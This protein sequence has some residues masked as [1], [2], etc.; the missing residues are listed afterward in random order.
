[1][2]ALVG[3]SLLML[4]NKII[5]LCVALLSACALL[6][7]YEP[8]SF[9]VSGDAAI[10]TGVIDG[11]IGK[12]LQT[13]FNEHPEIKTIILQNVEG[14]VNDEANLKAARLVRQ[15]GLDTLIP[16]DGMVASGGTDFFLA[17]VKRTARPG[18]MIG[19]HSWSDLML[20]GARVPGNSPE[21][22]KYLLYYKE[23]GIPAEFY[24]YTL[25]AAPSSGIHWMSTEEQRRYRVI[26]P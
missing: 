19:V 25:R 15:R 14:S 1:M 6:L 23:M 16:G 21:H 4:K 18:A 12:K 5:L 2:R 22:Q 8:V 10:M 13:L 26:T 20:D 7:N 9:S 3:V 11:D 17:G 24:W